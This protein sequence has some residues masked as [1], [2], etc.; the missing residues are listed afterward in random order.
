MK[1]GWQ[2]AT[3][4][5]LAFAGLMLVIGIFGAPFINARPL[6]LRD[7]LGPGPGFFPM[8]L[9]LLA[10]ALGA[11]LFVEVSRQPADADGADAP[12]PLAD[13]SVVK[14]LAI[15]SVLLVAAAWKYPEFPLLQKIG[16]SSDLIRGTLA[17]IIAG[18]SALAL[19]ALP[20]Q[21]E[22]MS[23]NGALLRIAAVLGLLTLTASALDPLGFR[24]SAFLFTGLLLY[25]LGIRSPLVLL[26]FMLAASLGVFYVFYHG[27]S[28]PL[29]I[30][31][32]DWALKPI[33]S[34]AIAFWSAIR[35]VLSLVLR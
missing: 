31:P 9:S 7:T 25:A 3:L 17:T 24:L 18:G 28:V 22:E 15:I 4:G 12:Y 27:L 14:Q 5:F 13:A 1:R 16:V 29:P 19:A 34:V 8:W 30:G 32:F 21:H 33:E 6:P 26:I 10:L 20:G 11:A 35:S 2:I 23:E